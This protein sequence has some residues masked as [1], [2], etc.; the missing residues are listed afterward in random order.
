MSEPP[1]W[2]QKSLEDMNRK[3]WES[4]CDGCGKCCLVKLEDEDDG[5]VYYT[6]VACRYL[7]LK[8]SRCTCYDSRTEKV[9][10]CTYLRPEDVSQF[11]W[12]PSSCSYRLIAEGKELPHWHPLVTG[13]DRQAVKRGLAVAGR[14]ISEDDID[15]DELEYFVVHWVD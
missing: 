15:P 7:D 6:N 12:L 5:K 9:P 14:C 11:H 13:D 4:L 8:E 3:E 1:F 10:D 2:Q